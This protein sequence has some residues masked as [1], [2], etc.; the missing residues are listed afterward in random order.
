MVCAP[1]EW[2]GTMSLEKESPMATH[3]A[4]GTAAASMPSC[5]MAGIGFANAHHRALD[6]VGEEVGEAVGAEHCADVAVEVGDQH[7]AVAAF[8]ERLQDVAGFVGMISCGAV[9]IVGHLRSGG[10]AVRIGERYRAFFAEKG[11]FDGDFFV[12]KRAEIVRPG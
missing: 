1:S 10:R 12:Q 5:Q 3:E 11:E 4:A 7:K 9:A 6:D 8:A 2:A